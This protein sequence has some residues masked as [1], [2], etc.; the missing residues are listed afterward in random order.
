[1]LRTSRLVAFAF[2]VTAL[3][4]C[5]KRQEP[6]PEPSSPTAAP[7]ATSAAKDP[8]RAKEL[9]AQGAVVIDVRTQQEFAGD[10]VDRA[11]NI[12]VQE[13][14]QRL[15]DVDKLV[16]GD[17]AKPIVLYCGTGKRAAAAKQALE[18]AGYTNVVNGGG[19]GDLK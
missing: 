15:P 16:G 12:P 19:I 11:E 9:L 2:S 10:H 6:P 7:A 8:A 1:M 18:A 5:S 13:L 3:A 4:A 17:K 14:G